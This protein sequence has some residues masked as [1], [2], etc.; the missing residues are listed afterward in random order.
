MSTTA[1]SQPTH[2]EGSDS[3]PKIR[4]VSKLDNMVNVECEAGNVFEASIQIDA[5]ARSEGFVRHPA[6]MQEA[7]VHGR[8]V[9]RAICKTLTQ[10]D[11]KRL[12]EKA[13]AMD[14][15]ALSM[16]PTTHPYAKR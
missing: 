13:Q 9:Y 6:P 3:L 5:W 12:R 16:K 10:E 15:M 11:I 2:A 7:V 14:R 1:P 4:I 8:R